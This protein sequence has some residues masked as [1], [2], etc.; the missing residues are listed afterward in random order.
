MFVKNY[1]S[2]STIKLQVT[3]LLCMVKM[4]YCAF[5]GVVWCGVAWCGV[6]VVWCSVVWYDLI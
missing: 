4:N 2:Y 5:Y 6:G 3:A 1:W